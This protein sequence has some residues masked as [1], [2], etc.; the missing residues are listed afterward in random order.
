MADAYVS[1]TFV[2]DEL[3]TSTKMN[4]LAANQANFHNGTA[5]GDGIILT[6]HLGNSSNLQIP[7][8]RLQNSTLDHKFAYS[9]AEQTVTTAQTILTGMSITITTAGKYLLMSSGNI[10]YTV[11]SYPRIGIYVNGSRATYAALHLQAGNQIIY[12]SFIVQTL[13]ANDVVTVQSIGGAAS[14]FE[15]TRLLALLVG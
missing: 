3:L 11:D 5:L 6:R 8:S 2:A 4:Q 13:S 15:G 14:F 12:Q 10:Q 7:F 9:T 1:I